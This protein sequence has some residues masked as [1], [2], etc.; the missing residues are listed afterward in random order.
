M[1]G[2]I[3]R[4][5]MDEVRAWSK[6]AIEEKNPYFNNLTACT[7]A[8]KAWA[9]NQVKFVFKYD[10]TMRSI[11]EQLCDFN[12]SYELVIVVDMEYPN[13]AGGFHSQMDLIN[14]AIANGIFNDRD[15]WVM[16]FHPD[17]DAN[18]LVDDESFDPLVELEYAMIFIQR[19]TRVQ[20]AS[21]KLKKLGYYDRYFE[22]YNVQEIFERRDALYRRLKNGDETT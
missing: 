16:G 21:E 6:H 9:E 3:E 14:D 11:F 4:A 13:D 7:Y 12:D 2:K 17:D 10:T 1:S 15:L 22:E 18:E 19:L 20:D 5:I 8:R